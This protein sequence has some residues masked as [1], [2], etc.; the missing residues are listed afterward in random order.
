[1]KKSDSKKYLKYKLNLKLTRK[2]SRELFGIFLLM[3]FSVFV[4]SLLLVSATAYF[5]VKTGLL[6]IVDKNQPGAGRLIV[7]MAVSS[8]VISIIILTI[9]GKLFLRPVNRIIAGMHSMS[10][11]DY[12]A[13]LDFG[14]PF[15]NYTVIRNVADSF[16]TMAEELQNTEVLRTD[17][18]NNFSHEFKTPIVSIAGFAKLLKKSNLSEEQREEY[19]NIIGEESLRLSYMATN[20]MNLT[21]VENQTILTDVEEYNLS[22]QL[23][24]AIL[25]LE[26]K[27]VSKNIEI[28]ADFDEYTVCGNQELLM[29]VWVN[30]LDN[31]VK[32]SPEYGEIRV[33]ICQDEKNTVIS[34]SNNGPKIPE[35]SMPR[36]FNKFY[37]ADESHASSGNG[38]GLAVVKKVVELHGGKVTAI[39]AEDLTVFTVSLPSKNFNI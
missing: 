28:F 21:R 37:Q 32:F 7:F 36:I 14:K 23:R 17:F 5:V 8:A 4:I 24:S 9:L 38:I 2:E 12:S 1:M 25:L 29:H 16:N 35:E 3:T 34:V 26:D 39:S 20:V 13:R 31:A 10:R 33:E 11:G 15:G 18:V 19:I 27:W 22:E 30:L 6:S